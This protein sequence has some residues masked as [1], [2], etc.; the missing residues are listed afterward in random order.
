M[1]PPAP[2]ANK[3]AKTNNR[4]CFLPA[5]WLWR[6]ACTRSHSELGRENSQ[7]RWYFVLRHG[8]V[9]RRQARKKQKHPLYS[10]DRL[11]RRP[12]TSVGSGFSGIRPGRSR[13][14][15]KR[16][17]WRQFSRKPCKGHRGEAKA[18]EPNV[19]AGD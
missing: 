17:L 12:P 2:E 13:D 18:K 3:K 6:E 5:W 19:P 14:L 8:R 10:I 4:F 15:P 9:G 7:R 1:F 16:P 11:R